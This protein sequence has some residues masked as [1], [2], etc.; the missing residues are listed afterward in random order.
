MF[1]RSSVPLTACELVT[2][3]QKKLLLRYSAMYWRISLEEAKE[4]GWPGGPAGPGGP[5]GPELTVMEPEE[6]Y[7]S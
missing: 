2:L 7:D 6:K 3:F 1:I 5:G 4:P